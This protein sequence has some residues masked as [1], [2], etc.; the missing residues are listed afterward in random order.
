[1]SDVLIKAKAAKAIKP[2]RVNTPVA[3]A[4]RRLVRDVV[5]DVVVEDNTMVA[6]VQ[7]LS[8]QKAHDA[9]DTPS[10]LK[11][12][13]SVARKKNTSSEQTPST[14]DRSRR[15]NS[16]QKA[17]VAKEQLQ[18]LRGSVSNKVARSGKVA[19][20][21]SPNDVLS[22]SSA[23]L[24]SITGLHDAVLQG[25]AIDTDSPDAML[26]VEIYYDD[27]FGHLVRADEYLGGMQGSSSESLELPEGAQWH[28]FV[29]QLDKHWLS[30][31]SKLTA[32]VANQGP[33]LAGTVHL[34]QGQAAGVSDQQLSR[35]FH[36]GGLKLVG[37]AWAGAGSAVIK[38]VSVFEST[39]GELQE[40]LTV[41]ANR[42]L[43]DLSRKPQQGHGFVIQL[44]ST[45]A[46][47]KRHQ[48]EL[49]TD[50]GE[51]I[52]G[53]PIELCLT[54]NTLSGL[55]KDACRSGESLDALMPVISSHE[56]QYPVSF[57]FNHY[58]AWCELYQVAPP[59]RETKLR[60]AVVVINPAN[61]SDW[62]ADVQAEQS[63]Q[64][65]FDQ[66]L[67][68][69]QVECFKVSAL[70]IIK[71]LQAAADMADVVV[72]IW[73]RDRL[74]PHAL[75]VMASHL[76]GQY[77]E[78]QAPH[79]W[80]Y[81]DD[82]VFSLGSSNRSDPWLK[83]DWDETLF[84]SL[85][86][87]S[88]GVF[89]SSELV[90]TV[91][92]D[93]ADTLNA[94]T[95]EE[96]ATTAWHAFMACVVAHSNSSK[97]VPVH[98]RHVL[99][100]SPQRTAPDQPSANQSRLAAMAWLVDHQVPGAQ[101]GVEQSVPRVVWPMPTEGNLPRVSVIVPTRNGVELLRVAV[102]GV[103]DKTQYRALELLVIDNDSDCEETLTYLRELAQTGVKLL[104]Y[105]KPF[106][107]SA[108][109]NMAA[110]AASG[111]LLLFLN[112]DVEI[113]DSRW[114]TEMVVQFGRADV[115]VVGKK[116][117]W[118]NGLVQHGGVVVGI[119]GLAAHAFNDCWQNDPGYMGLNQVD[120]EQS[121]VTAACLMI[122]RDD[123]LA[124][125]GLDETNLPVAFND[126]D[127]CLRIRELGKRVVL[128]TR[129]PLIHH[130]SASRG[131][132]D[133]PQKQARARRERQF[134]MRRWMTTQAPFTDPY[135]HPGLNR[136]FL[137]GPYGGL[138]RVH[139]TKLSRDG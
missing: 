93:Y 16:K 44:P 132:E 119:N 39:Y 115:G 5:T 112:N 2:T 65:V 83:P 61:A 9:L 136:D 135:Y 35:V 87:V 14:S 7:G 70:A 94:L 77:S 113:V 3:P 37:W 6:A 91:L 12:L 17:G 92:S 34:G 97:Q 11:T 69:T 82:D 130:E 114:L 120:R 72:P 81:V 134:F 117:L 36:G 90:K 124:V 68:E 74:L 31:A 47:G 4:G 129:F 18:P 73:A 1:M 98:V 123:Y 96:D 79:S 25:W 126:V 51:P 48:L 104:S 28:G 107:Y 137:V 38:R 103:L 32:R 26:A 105:P 86:Y 52:N 95:H 45:L 50:Q 102:Q 33:W 15:T 139:D 55:V 21:T 110:Q 75:D 76:S 23:M 133:T 71:G 64:S 42:S 116:L 128:T 122:R 127:L 10:S 27:V 125:G 66:R 131:K 54:S 53:S 78:T 67:P 111:E 20:A 22:R 24:G 40:I 118:P 109:N 63:I 43:S 121:A 100:Q 88:R 106:N 138:G 57:G 60:C 56:Q 30:G 99:Y 84:Y 108:I 46:D 85:D 8:A 80:G 13:Q 41:K 59:M 89:F 49:V 58:P 19:A 101:L 62:Q 29:A